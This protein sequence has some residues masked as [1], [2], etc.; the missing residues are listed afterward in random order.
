MILWE[1][2]SEANSNSHLPSSPI[3]LRSLLWLFSMSPVDI[4]LCLFSD[5]GLLFLYML[6]LY[7][8]SHVPCQSRDIP[9]YLSLSNMCWP[10]EVLQGLL[11]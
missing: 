9:P 3:I 11:L 7:F 1:N 5:C 10:S 4:F 6:V 2:A 8:L